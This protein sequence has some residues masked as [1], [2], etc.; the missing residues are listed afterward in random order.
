MKRNSKAVGYL[1]DKEQTCIMQPTVLHE[2]NDNV[3]SI[4][5]PVGFQTRMQT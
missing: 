1:N 2:E 4:W 3:C 5:N